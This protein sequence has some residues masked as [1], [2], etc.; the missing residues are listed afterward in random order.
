MCG[1]K[2]NTIKK[3]ESW[4][5]DKKWSG[6]VKEIHPFEIESIGSFVSK[7][8]KWNPLSQYDLSFL[9]EK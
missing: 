7:E 4:K 8:F 6:K 1:V 5:Y 3:I 9:S 2:S